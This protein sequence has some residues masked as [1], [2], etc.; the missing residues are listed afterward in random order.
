MSELVKEPYAR[1][2]WLIMDKFKVLPTNP[3]FMALTENQIGFVLENMVYDA[4]EKNRAQQARKGATFYEDQDTSWVDEDIKD[5]NPLR[6][7]EDLEA[8]QEHINNSS[9]KE[10]Y[11]QARARYQSVDE[12]NE[13]VE[14]GGKHAEDLEKERYKQEQLAKLFG[15]AQQLTEDS[16]GIESISTAIDLFNGEYDDDEDYF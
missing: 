8:I 12:W 16:E 1:N 4:N 7:E 13:F 15:E 10:D 11:E 5:F 3:D 9:T 6:D 14:S 2:L